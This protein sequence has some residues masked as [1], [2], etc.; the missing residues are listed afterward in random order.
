MFLCQ[1]QWCRPLLLEAANLHVS[2][3][4]ISMP[5]L[6]SLLL[7]S[8]KNGFVEVCFK[9]ISHHLSRRYFC[10]HQTK[11]WKYPSV[12][13]GSPCMVKF[14]RDFCLLNFISSHNSLL[15]VCL[16]SSPQKYSPTFTVDF[17][18]GKSLKYLILAGDKNWPAVSHRHYTDTLQYTV[19]TLQPYKLY[20]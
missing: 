2:M 20:S 17:L 10:P 3:S 8:D 5:L 6:L 19:Y 1:L 12:L 14:K 9:V 7:T 4:L 11:L 15:R 16:F 18:P 13:T